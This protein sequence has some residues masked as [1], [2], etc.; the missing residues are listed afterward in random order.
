MVICLQ[1]WTAG[2]AHSAVAREDF[3]SDVEVLL[4]RDDDELIQQKVA[5]AAR[6][7]QRICWSEV[8]HARAARPRTPPPQADDLGDGGGGGI[9]CAQR[10][11]AIKQT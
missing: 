9:K 4:D 3:G 1:C 2:T 11:A 7:L 8:Q 6:E 10:L 5:E